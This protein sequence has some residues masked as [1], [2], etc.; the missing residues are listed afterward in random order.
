MKMAK[1][2]VTLNMKSALEG[3]IDE[4]IASIETIVEVSGC[5]M[6]WGDPTAESVCWELSFKNERQ[7]EATLSMV[8]DLILDYPGSLK[9][10][11]G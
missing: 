5:R 11:T 8:N 6:E 3:I 4:I 9:V 7:E 1:L 10:E 2:K